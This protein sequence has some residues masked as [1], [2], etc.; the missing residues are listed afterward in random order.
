MDI[1][2]LLGR[3]SLAEKIGQLN[4]PNI[5]GAD[6]T[7]AGT[8]SADLERRIRHGEVGSLAAGAPLPRLA[9]LQRI[10]VEHSPHGIPLFLTLDVIHGHRT[11]FPLPV[12]LAG[13]FDTDLV[14]R[15]ARAAAI[16]GAA[17]GVMPG[18]RSWRPA[19]RS[20]GSSRRPARTASA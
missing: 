8:A 6:S 4:H 15:T 20:T 2:E 18:L 3:M 17:S 12:A 16:E 13:A 19:S 9:E 1:D 14:G 10:A 11:I 5:G 7:G